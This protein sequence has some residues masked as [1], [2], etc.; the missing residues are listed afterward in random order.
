MRVM[1]DTLRQRLCRVPMLASLKTR[2]ESPR[3][4]GP[5]VARER[6]PGPSLR[7]LL[8]PLSA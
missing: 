8:R 2:E 3:R 5:R 7:R 4:L 6:G 1:L